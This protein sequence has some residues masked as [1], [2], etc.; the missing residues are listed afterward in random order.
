MDVRGCVLSS[1]ALRTSFQVSGAPVGST[2]LLA[3]Q[4]GGQTARG[5]RNT[6]FLGFQVDHLTQPESAARRQC[7]VFPQALWQHTA[8]GIS[9]LGDKAAVSKK[10]IN[11]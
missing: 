10:L 2:A 7:A 11:E 1:D 9:A 8:P 4:N 5:E 6:F 3:Q